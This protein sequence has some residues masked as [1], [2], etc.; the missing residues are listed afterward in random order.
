MHLSF[1]VVFASVV[2]MPLVLFKHPPHMLRLLSDL[3]CVALKSQL[4]IALPQIP[5]FLENCY[6]II[7]VK[8]F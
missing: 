5:E 6:T 8:L 2:C 4:Q 7:Y 3:L 1:C